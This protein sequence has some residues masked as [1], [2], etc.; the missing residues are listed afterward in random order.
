M[1]IKT[2]GSSGEKMMRLKQYELC[3]KSSFNDMSI[4]VTALGVPIVCGPLCGQQID[5]AKDQHPF[6]HE[7][8]LADDGSTT[9]KSID[10]LIGADFYW[11]IVG[12]KIKRD[13]HTGLAA[14]SSKLGWLISG[15]V[16]SNT[17][18]CSVNVTSTHVF[19]IECQASPQHDPNEQ[20]SEFWRLDLIG[21]NEEEPSVYDEKFNDCVSFKNSRYEVLLPFKENHPKSPNFSLSVKRLKSLKHRLTKSPTLYNQYSEVIKEQL[22]L[23]IIEVV[24]EEEET[25]VGHVTYLPHREVV[26]E[27]KM[28]TKVRVVFDASAKGSNGVSLNDC[29]YK[30]DCLVPLLYDLLLKFRANSIALTAD[31]EKAYLQ[32]SVLPEHRDFLRF[33]WFMSDDVNETEIKKFRFCRVIFG[34]T[35][36]QSLLTATVNNHGRKYERVD[37]EFARKVK[38]HFYVDDLNTGVKTSE[39][40]LTLYKN[41]K[42]RFM[43]GNFNLRK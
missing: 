12:S 29:L 19:K 40:G 36:S 7:L 14:I 33:L 30:G 28:S 1:G 27:D 31:I 38:D 23:G 8:Q 32:I 39:E 26:R 42:S 3:L 6:L 4:Y 22:Q 9:A 43:E 16:K 17:E 13:D 5:L 24:P 21:I 34:A 15:P 11:N 20:V 41:M 2:F 35:C 10:L 25:D 18:S 37:P